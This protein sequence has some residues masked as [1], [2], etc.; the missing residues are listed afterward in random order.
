MLL[1][2]GVCGLQNYA[3]PI[4]AAAQESV[5]LSVASVK[6]EGCKR[7][8]EKDILALI[9]ELSK[10]SVD[11]KNLSKQIQMVN[12]S[13]AVKLNADFQKSDRDQ[14]NVIVKVQEQKAEHVGINLNNSG[15]KYTGDWRLMTTYTNANFSNSSD[16]FGIAAVTSPGHWDD[17]K[18]TALSYRVL[19]P[20]AGASMYFAYSYSDVD[21]GNIANFGG[22]SMMATG[23]GQ[24]FGWHYQQNMEYTSAKKQILD[25]GI[26]HKRYNN[27]QD[28][29]YQNASLLHDGMDFNVT[30]LSATY[31]NSRRSSN[32]AFAYTLGYTT[33]LNGDVNTYDSYRSGSDSHFNIW[34][35]G[36]SYQ[37]RMPSDWISNFRLNGQYTKNNLLTTEQL[38]AGGMYSV[39]GFNER[40]ISAD[41]GYVGS[42]EFYTPEL[43]KNQRI[44]FFTDFAHLFN[45]HANTGE[46]SQENIA[47]AGIGYRYSN[48]KNGLAASVDY[49]SIVK[50]IDNPANRDAKKWHVM[51]SKNF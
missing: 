43:A 46:F 15:N 13:H 29:T 47:S 34:Q 3:M 31:I 16:S 42:L 41:N 39:R 38:G 23:K 9:P 51:V 24:T 26:D 33:N 8:K 36:L 20:K 27:E 50:D 17:V 48:E 37:Y 5:K 14:Y 18:Q 10:K 40:A 28:Y 22:L 7:W 49:A 35:T 19:L 30:T 25:F 21:M 6:V 2:L 11:I 12:D 32:K 45:N 44:V 1:S 4:P